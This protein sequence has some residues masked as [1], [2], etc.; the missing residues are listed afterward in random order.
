MSVSPSK[1]P[2][3]LYPFPL[4][5]SSFFFFSDFTKASKRRSPRQARKEWRT[6]SKEAHTR[7]IPNRRAGRQLARVLGFGVEIESADVGILVGPTSAALDLDQASMAD[8]LLGGGNSPDIVRVLTRHRP[9]RSRNRA[10]VGA[11]PMPG[12]PRTAPV[13]RYQNRIMEVLIRCHSMDGCSVC[14]F[15]RRD[16]NLCR[17]KCP[18]NQ[19]AHT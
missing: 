3:V 16:P 6:R 5:L 13:F 4:T 15:G 11:F 17:S 9:M 10:R 12:E 18:K 14:K 7:E 8:D 1:K 2:P 19:L